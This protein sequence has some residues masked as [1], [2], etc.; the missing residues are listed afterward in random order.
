MWPVTKIRYG[1]LLAFLACAGCKGPPAE[2]DQTAGHYNEVHTNNTT[3][4]VDDP[5]LPAEQ[6]QVPAEPDP[7]V[8]PE[9]P[10]AARELVVRYFRLL[11]DGRASEARRLW[12]RLD[13]ALA[14]ELKFGDITR[15][16][17]Q[18][19]QAGAIEGAAGSIFIEVPVN[20]IGRSENGDPVELAG[21]VAL[22]RVNN[23]PGSTEAQRRW[24]IFRADLQPHP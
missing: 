14:A 22:R 13:D 20:L 23:I 7:A 19:G 6:A 4:S 16:Q 18:V 21:S 10:E 2:S 17:S 8:D 12:G 9:S 5:G 24:H 15:Y 3:T 1:L 11:Q